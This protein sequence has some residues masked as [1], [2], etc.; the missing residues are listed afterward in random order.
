MRSAF[1]LRIISG[2]NI[3]ICKSGKSADFSDLLFHGEGV[4]DGDG[5]CSALALFHGEE[6][7]G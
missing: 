4:V 6:R 2:K 3:F 5:I 1:A 7:N